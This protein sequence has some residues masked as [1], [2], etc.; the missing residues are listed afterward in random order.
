MLL[1]DGRVRVEFAAEVSDV[2]WGLGHDIAALQ[3][4][5][6]HIRARA[7]PSYFVISGLDFG[8]V[9]LHRLRQVQRTGGGCEQ[10]GGRQE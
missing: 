7:F 9:E 1:H 2:R 8:S 4:A 3:N 5:Y 10:A 6:V